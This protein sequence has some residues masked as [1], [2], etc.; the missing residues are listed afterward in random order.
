MTSQDKVFFISKWKKLTYDKFY[1]I[2]YRYFVRFLLRLLDVFSRILFMLVIWL[3]LGDLAIVLVVTI[4]MT[5]LTIISI[6]TGGYVRVF[7]FCLLFFPVRFVCNVFPGLFRCGC[8]LVF[9]LYCF[10]FVF[11]VFGLFGLFATVTTLAACQYSFGLHKH[12]SKQ[13]TILVR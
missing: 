2:N 10:V 7:H 4:E 3:T 5:I 11:L 9:I 13:M 6:L 12:H 1:R 8:V